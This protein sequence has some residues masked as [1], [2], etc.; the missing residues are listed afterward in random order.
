M[1][2]V[3]KAKPATSASAAAGAYV[4]AVDDLRAWLL[5]VGVKHEGTVF[6]LMDA[7]PWQ[8]KFEL[9]LARVFA[10]VFAAAAVRGIVKSVDPFARA[11]ANIADEQAALLIADLSTTGKAA[12]RLVIK[13]GIEKNLTN[14]QIAKQVA[15]IVGLHPRYANAVLTMRDRMAD[16]GRKVA[17]IDKA[18]T[19]YADRLRRLRARTIARTEVNASFNAGR[20]KGWRDRVS[21]GDLPS[22]VGRVWIANDPCVLCKELSFLDP[23]SVWE[24]FVDPTSGRAFM[25][26]P[27][28]A[29]CKCSMALTNIGLGRRR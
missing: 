9:P 11:A 25:A 15:D 22:D 4:A 29:N 5:R 26:P 17:E 7:I 3:D 2:T 24:P 16:A 6:E 23:V 28:H 10:R 20:L 14:Q 18:V 13:R 21:G 12:V 8:E 1:T 27:A 19:R